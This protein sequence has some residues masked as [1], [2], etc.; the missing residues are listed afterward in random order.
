MSTQNNYNMITKTTL[1]Y[2][3]FQKEETEIKMLIPRELLN[4]LKNG[5]HHILRHDGFFVL[6]TRN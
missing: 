2:V 6:T 3:V 5:N 1:I 4:I